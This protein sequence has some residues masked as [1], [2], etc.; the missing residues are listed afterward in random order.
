MFRSKSLDSDFQNRLLDFPLEAIGSNAFKGDYN[1]QYVVLNSETPPALGE[2]VFEGCDY[3]ADIDLSDRGTRQQMQEWQAYV[4][5]LGLTCRVWRAQD[6]TASSP[7]IS[8]KT[9]C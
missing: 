5:A 1:I 7:E 2:N 9:A 8:T 4:D 3:L 6:P